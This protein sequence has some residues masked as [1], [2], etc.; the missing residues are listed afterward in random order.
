M[1][2]SKSVPVPP[3]TVYRVKDA[4]WISRGRL[5]S[6][7]MVVHVLPGEYTPPQTVRVSEYIWDQMMKHLNGEY[8]GCERATSWSDLLMCLRA[9]YMISDAPL[10]KYTGEVKVHQVGRGAVSF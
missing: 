7:D 3:I 6:G 1:G 8:D 10:P 2:N 9:R 5:P 4:E